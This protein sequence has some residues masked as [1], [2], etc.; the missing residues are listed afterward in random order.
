MHKGRLFPSLFLLTVTGLFLYGV[1]H[2]LA[3][4]F[5]KGDAYPPYSSFRADPLGTK[6]FYE[7]LCLLPGVETTRNVDPLQKASGLSDAAL[8]LFG[9]Q[10]SHFSAMEQASVKALEDVALGGGRIVISFFPTK[11][12]PAPRSEDKGKKDPRLEE[13]PDKQK[14]KEKD[15]EEEQGLYRK[16]YVDLSKRWSVETGFSKEK[17]AEAS[18]SAPEKNLPATL[19]WHSTLFLEPHDDAWR[20]VYVRAGK[21]V[22]IE[23]S[24][25]KGSI[26]LFSDSFFL[27]NEAMKSKRYSHLLSWLCGAHK[28]I[29]FD[30]THLG[31]RKSPGIATLLRKYGLAPFLISLLVL[32]LLAIWKQ[33]ARFV[34]AYEEDEQALVDPGKDSSTGL[35][36]LLHRN[37][38]LHDIL[39]ACLEEWK[40]SFTHGKQNL[41]GLLPR[42]QEIIAEHRAQ[43]RKN[44][45][46]VL[47]YRKIS[48]LRTRR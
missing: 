21:P 26:V 12:Q 13:N 8:F 28:K 45:N 15:Q 19:A 41:S 5:E 3:L 23:R 39:P 10:G 7:A 9:L 44:R 32:A 30:E 25:G 31:V 36:N 22:L 40:R 34:P 29:V 42:I 43:P 24:F 35:T 1:T 37:I 48:A 11:G 46:P 6:A 27:S 38:S 16:E 2:L 18:L 17:S 47:A 33:S 4:R 20:T 14:D